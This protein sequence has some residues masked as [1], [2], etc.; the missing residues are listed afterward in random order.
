M[1]LVP[2]GWPQSR[3]A[4]GPVPTC[5]APSS[6]HKKHIKNYTPIIDTLIHFTS[7]VYLIPHWNLTRSEMFLVP[8][9]WPQSRGAKGPVPTCI[10]PSSSHKKHIKNYTPIIDTLI[11]FTSYVYLIPHWNLA[12][13]EMFLV[14]QGW[15]QS[16]GTKGPVPTCI[17]PSSS[18]KKHIKNHTP[19]NAP[20]I[21]TLIHFT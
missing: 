12:R 3:G 20:I 19:I 1:F 2:Q 8:Q 15:P 7:Y 16:R 9:G 6:S 5:I 4:K 13:S 21:D 11:H 18:H 14:P 10:A 17:T